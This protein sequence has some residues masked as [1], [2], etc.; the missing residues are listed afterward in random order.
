MALGSPSHESPQ[1]PTYLPGFLMG[2]RTQSP[3]GNVSIN[4]LSPLR[5]NRSQTADAHSTILMR[6]F[7]HELSDK[8]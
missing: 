8:P 1:K 2:E 6:N 5:S 3:I 4:T 7:H